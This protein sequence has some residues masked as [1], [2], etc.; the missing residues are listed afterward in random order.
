MP[1]IFGRAFAFAWDAAK[2][3]SNLT[4]HGVSFESVVSFDFDS[5]EVADDDRA[6]YGEDRHVA[7]GT[8]GRRVHVL[9]FTL[10]D[11][12]RPVATFRVISLRK[13]NIEEVDAYEQERSRS[14][15]DPFIAHPD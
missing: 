9:V 15:G 13:A 3:A 8:I 12:D 2:A 6:D 7:L 1:T 10:R 4:K 5:C 11:L 14:D